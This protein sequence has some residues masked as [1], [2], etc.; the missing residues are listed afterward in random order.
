MAFALAQFLRYRPHLYHLTAVENLKLIE[1]TAE[2][3]CAMLPIYFGS[4]GRIALKG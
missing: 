2:P 3:I 1:V 4:A